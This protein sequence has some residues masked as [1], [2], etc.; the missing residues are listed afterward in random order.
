MATIKYTSKQDAI[1]KGIVKKNGVFCKQSV[2]ETWHS[3]G[4]L[5]LDHSRFSGDDRLRFG[6]KFIG[7]YQYLRRS[8]ITTVSLENNK[9]NVSSRIQ[10]DNLLDAIDRYRKAL[11]S[12]PREFWPMVRRICLEDLPPEYPASISDR[13]KA[14]LSFLYRTDLCRGLDYVI[15][16]YTHKL[17]KI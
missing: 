4:W 1:N 13:K 5:E 12:I 2:L 3:K 15:E 9:I 6:L 7:D 8:Q 14:Y 17:K 10:S 16:A 11:R